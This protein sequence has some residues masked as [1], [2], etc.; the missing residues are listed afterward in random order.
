MQSAG[1]SIRRAAG[2]LACLWIAGAGGAVHAQSVTAV[3]RIPIAA[4]SKL[5]RALQVARCGT[6]LSSTNAIRLTAVPISEA[7][8]C[9][10]GTGAEN[11]GVIAPNS[12]DALLAHYRG[13]GGVGMGALVRFSLPADLAGTGELVDVYNPTGPFPVDGAT[14]MGGRVE[15]RESETSTVVFFQESGD[16]WQPVEGAPRFALQDPFATRIG[17][18]IILG[19][20]E[21][22]STAAGT[23]YR[24]V[25]YRGRDLASLRRFAQGP[26]GMKDIRLVELDE[27]TAAAAGGRIGVFTRPQGELAR[28]LGAAGDRGSIGFTVIG[29]LSDLTEQRIREAPL[30]T[31]D[32]IASEWG[33][34]NDVTV[35]EDGTLGV[36]G[37]IAKYDGANNRHYYPMAFRF[38]P[39]SRARSD[40]QILAERS[41]LPPGPSKKP[42]LGDVL[43]SSR[44]VRHGDGV[45]TLWMG[46]GD[47]VVYSKLIPDPF[48]RASTIEP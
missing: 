12:A 7:L 2:A 15:P 13:S 37:H 25:F 10:Y 11:L 43:F 20:V 32:F 8:R 27:T 42:D 38:D 36:L 21:V 44:L 19:G 17:N 35:L 9:H 45:A 48:V 46:G 39:V 47:T 29:D 5:T 40:F 30:I 3:V 24:T 26:P 22:I 16:V 6:S 33:G 31:H 1:S 14:V 18:E 34:V 4:G 28:T 23:T 41:E